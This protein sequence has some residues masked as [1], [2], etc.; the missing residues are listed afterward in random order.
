MLFP[1]KCYSVEIFFSVNNSYCR[2]VKP[3]CVKP[4]NR[5]EAFIFNSLFRKKR[6]IKQMRIFRCSLEYILMPSPIHLYSRLFLFFSLQHF[7]CIFNPILPLGI[8]ISIIQLKNTTDIWITCADKLVSINNDS[9]L[10]S[11]CGVRTLH[12]KQR[13]QQ[14]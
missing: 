5:L 4:I 11:V 1:P 9:Q 7:S 10:K 2:C 6:K 14:I 13:H 8:F 12:C 3:Y